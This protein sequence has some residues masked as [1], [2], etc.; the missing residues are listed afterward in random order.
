M[1]FFLPPLICLLLFGFVLQKTLKIPSAA[2]PFLSCCSVVLLLIFGGIVNILPA[3]RLIIYFAFAVSG[4]Y[5]AYRHRKEFIRYLASPGIIAFA[6]GSIVL[7]AIYLTHDSFYFQWDEYSHWG[8]FYQHIFAF[9]SFHQFTPS[10]MIHQSYPQALTVLY[11]FFSLFSGKFVEAHTFVSLGIFLTACA[12]M[13]LAPLRWKKPLPAL[14]G[15]AI[16]PLFFILFPYSEPY[17]TVYLDT[18]LGAAF[19]AC[20]LLTLFLNPASKRHTLAF[21]LGLGALSQ[22]KEMGLLLGLVCLAL[23]WCGLLLANG[24]NKTLLQ[25]VKSNF[26]LALVTKAAVSLGGLMLPVLLW[27]AFL[28]VTGTGQD[29]FSS[30]LSVNFFAR[31][32]A[33]RQGNDPVAASIWELFTINFRHMPVVYNGYGTPLAIGLLLTVFGIAAG[34]YLWFKKKQRGHATALFLLPVFYLAYSFSIFYTYICMMS[35]LEGLSNASFQ[36]YFSSFLI[37]W[38]MFALGCWLLYSKN[39]LQRFPSSLQA[40]ALAAILAL[41]I[42]TALQKDVLNL[43]LTKEEAGRPNFGLVSSQMLA[44]MPQGSKVWLIAQGDDGI[45]LHMYHYTLFPAEVTYDLPYSVG[46]A[47]SETQDITQEEFAALAKENQVDFI[48]VYIVDDPFVLRFGSL[49]SDSLTS[50][51][52]NNLP[53]LYKVS[54]QEPPFQLVVETSLPASAAH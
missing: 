37:G 46:L 13:L 42:N 41:Q 32:A 17:I 4:L 14:L 51:V 47:G 34:V 11:Y 40:V 1:L 35:D 16:V 23:F 8:P 25:T 44:Q 28:A 21:A 19:G 33:A 15:V 31:M 29:Q 48:V 2:A 39:I 45:Y 38:C 50:V 30:P 10:Q 43:R 52:H 9:N 26:N 20:L 3:A 22:V 54:S 7:S 24:Q 18:A 5:F 53:S 6:A 36:R 12:S 49:F 27:K